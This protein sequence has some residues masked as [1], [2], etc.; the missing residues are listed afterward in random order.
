M[1]D[2]APG[3]APGCPTRQKVWFE[4]R[5]AAKRF[6][7]SKSRQHP[8]YLASRPYLC[9][10]GRWHLTTQPPPPA[11]AVPPAAL[12]VIRAAIDTAP[13]G[14]TTADTAQHIA[15]ELAAAGWQFT[16][17]PADGHERA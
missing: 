5:S 10:C 17:E 16:A 9:P 3:P 7:R 15:A 14:A 11:P 12:A 2:D 8:A 6:A 1:N 13:P 4:T